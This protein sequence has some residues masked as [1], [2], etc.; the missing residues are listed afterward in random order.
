M[1]EPPINPPSDSDFSATEPTP[2]TR[3][4]WLTK[5]AIWLHVFMVVVATTCLALGWWQLKR[6]EA[7]NMRSYAYALEWPFFAGAAVYMWFRTLREDAELLKNPAARAGA[8]GV[9]PAPDTEDLPELQNPARQAALARVADDEPD[10]ELDAYNAYLASLNQ[11][12]AK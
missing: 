10:P 7:G 9:T 1:Q 3:H 8:A 6:G 5:K 4:P 12:V 11:Q 2:K